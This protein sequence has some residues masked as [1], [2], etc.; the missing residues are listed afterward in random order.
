MYKALHY[1]CY[2]GCNMKTFVIINP[3]S[4]KQRRE[5]EDW[6]RPVQINFPDA[7]CAFTQSAGHATELAARAVSEGYEQILVAGGDGTINEAARALVGKSAALGII[8]KG[9]G[10]GLARELGIPLSYE[11][12]LLTLQH[13]EPV[14]CDVGQANG[15]Y[16]FNVA[17][18]GIEAEIARQFAEHGKTGERGMWP[19]FKLGIQTVFS[20]KPKFLEV[21]YN[22][23]SELMAPLTLVFANGAQYGSNFIIAPRASLVDGLFDMV[24]VPN[25]PKWQLALAAPTFF[26]KTFRPLQVSQTQHTAHAIIKAD[27]EIVYHLDGEPKTTKNRLEISLLPRALKLLIPRGL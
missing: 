13:C 12:A 17:G 26:S 16:F 7:V 8:P 20:Y 9:S 10:N 23:K 5:K 27:E 3:V 21:H 19:Y 22:G 15:E 11:Q 18:V 14:A 1:I 4:G 6:L 24:R 2:N 25:F